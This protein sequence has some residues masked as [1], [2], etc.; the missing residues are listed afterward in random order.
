M[1][2]NR[3]LFSLIVLAI[4]VL[5]VGG[6]MILGFW[7]TKGGQGR[8]GG[9]GH[10]DHDHSFTPAIETIVQIRPTRFLVR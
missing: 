6:A 7:Q 1:R 4:F 5:V 10:E 3:F 8:G 9:G 2:I